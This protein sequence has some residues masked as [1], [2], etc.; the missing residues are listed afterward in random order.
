MNYFVPELGILRETVAPESRT[1]GCR[2]VELVDIE[3]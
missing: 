3:H 2:G 1:I